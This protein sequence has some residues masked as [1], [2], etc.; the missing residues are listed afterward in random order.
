MRDADQNIDKLVRAAL[1]RARQRAR[2]DGIEFTLTTEDLNAL[3]EACEGR[4][5]VSGL[6][7]SLDTFVDAL[8]KHPFAPSI[9]RKDSSKGYTLK[10]TRLVCT[11][12]NFAMNQWGAEVLRRVS[13]GV[14]AKERKQ[15][16]HNTDWIAWDRRMKQKLRRMERAAENMTGED[17]TEQR[18]RIAAV[19][20]AMTIGPVGLSDAAARAWRRRRRIS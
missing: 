20:R 3:W 4:C 15:R 11:A 8:V 16:D 9:D 17:L 10:N 12:A 6:P 2:R 18:Q 1:K 19:K 7:F 5:A 14:V 13:R